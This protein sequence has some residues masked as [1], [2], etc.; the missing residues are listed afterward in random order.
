MPSSTNT[1]STDT[2]S[3]RGYSKPH[4][5][6]LVKRLEQADCGIDC[7]PSGDADVTT[8]VVCPTRPI[9]IVCIRTVDLHAGAVDLHAGYLPLLM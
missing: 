4:Q 1:S 2:S 9:W 7:V 5:L 8:F 3:A 6:C